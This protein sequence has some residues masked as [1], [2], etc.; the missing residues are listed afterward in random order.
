MA[1]STGVFGEE[2]VC[3][4]LQ[5]KGY[6]IVTRN[7]RSRFG[8]IDIIAQNEQ[9]IAFVE[10][11]TRSPGAIAQPQA[12]VGAAKRRKIIKTAL[13]FLQEKHLALQ[14]RFDVAALTVEPTQQRARRLDYFENAFGAEDGYAAF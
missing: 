10:V 4:Y 1:N 11:K 13:Q 7:Y 3:K 14:P 12:A 5:K 6:T 8:E 9:Y 2:Y